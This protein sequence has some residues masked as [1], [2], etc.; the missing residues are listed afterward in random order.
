[1]RQ[2]RVGAL[3]V[4]VLALLLAPGCKTIPTRNKPLESYPPALSYQ[5]DNIAPGENNSDSLEVILTFSGGGT[6]AAAFCYGVL[7]K[8][9]DTEITWEGKRRRLLD[10]VD[11]I[12]SVSGGSLAA[13][14]YGLFGERTFD[15]FPKKVLYQSLQ[16]QLL[17]QI[18][19]LPNLVKLASPY[20]GRADLLADNFN[21]NIFEHK[22]FADLLERNKRPYII[23]NSTDTTLGSR[24]DFTQRQFNLLYSDLSSYPVA[25]AVA[26]SAAFPGLLTPITLRNYEK[27][28][29]FVAPSWIGEELEYNDLERPRYRQAVDAES[30]IEPGRPYIHLSDGGVSDNLGILPI[31]QIV[32]GNFPSDTANAAF[33]KGLIKKV[34]IICVNAKRVSRQDWDMTEK[35][36]GTIK[37][38]STATSVPLNSFSDWELAYLRMYLKQLSEKQIV[39]R[40]L[41]Q[42]LGEQAVTEQFPELAG[43]NI[44]FSLVEVAFDRI[45]NEAERAYLNKIPTAFRL[46][47]E[48]V[49]RLRLD[50]ATI[51]DNHPI[52]QELLSELR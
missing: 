38:L 8:L 22:T 15:D 18:I 45:E 40:K 48:Q 24:F 30:Y 41:T 3:I 12:S 36:L 33:H 9:R 1:M 31:V 49:D 25:N 27:K 51:L 7:E 47:R 46:R 43:Q 35:V 23:I 32:S 17:K 21:Q 4:V 26:A 11:V 20:Y 2:K 19:R 10:E 13:A 44:S 52:F 37:V 34:I 39:R 42:Q 14:Y 29:D 28:E 50:A 6:R 16:G 5:Y